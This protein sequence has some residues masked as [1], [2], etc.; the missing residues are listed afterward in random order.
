[1]QSRQTAEYEAELIWKTPAG[2]KRFENCNVVDFSDGGIAVECPADIP[3]SSDIILRAESANL[4]ALSQVRH[5]TWSGS[6][7]LLG[8]QF[9]AR[10]TTAHPPSTEPDHYEILRLSQSAD[11]ESIQRVYRQL[12]KRYHPDN[13]ETADP[14]AFLRVN[15]AWRI[16]SDPQKRRT[17]DQE[18]NAQGRESRPRF[19]L[20]SRE[21]F[22]GLK[23]EQ[24]RRMAILCLLYRRR[25]IDYQN[26]EMSILDIEQLTGFT[27]EEIG[28]AL[29]YLREK[30][31]VQ[32]TDTSQFCIGADGIDY[33]EGNPSH[34]ELLAIAAPTLT[35][36]HLY[37]GQPPVDAQTPHVNGAIP[38]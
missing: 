17:Y 33:V 30:K 3:V 38:L 36:T 10:T 18:R 23:G 11:E 19:Q 32:M 26:P 8:M 16:L 34:P 25:T 15:Q 22:I 12:A 7:Y 4:A 37:S 24:N 21:F 2:E 1:M 14:Q 35:Q 27:R 28:F 9:L 29:W 13:S 20:R 5:C 31:M 6:K